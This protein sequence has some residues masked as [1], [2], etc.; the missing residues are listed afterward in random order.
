MIKKNWRIHITNACNSRCFFCHN[1]NIENKKNNTFIETKYLSSF[2]VW[3][4]SEGDDVSITGGEPLLHPDLCQIIN[5][6]CNLPNIYVHL[7]TNGLLLE[8]KREILYQTNLKDIHIN[9]ATIDKRKYQKIYGID[10]SPQYLETIDSFGIKYNITINC[11]ILKKVN[12]NRQMIDEMI[13]YTR[14]RNFSLVF[15]ENFYNAA[16]DVSKGLEFQDYFEKILVSY[17]YKPGTVTCGRKKYYNSDHKIIIA[18]PCAP[19]MAWNATDDVDA[20]VVTETQKIKRFTNGD[21]IL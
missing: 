8:E 9:L 2:I 6:F 15:I 13:N 10:L 5:I 16:S 17:G 11:I 19:A 4:V 12:D 18:A 20:F 1:E 21:I 14:A 3:H 7:N